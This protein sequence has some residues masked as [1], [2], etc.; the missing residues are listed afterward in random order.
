MIT[1]LQI[2]I[3]VVVSVGLLALPLVGIR[4]LAAKS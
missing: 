3:S 2:G 4:F 1:L